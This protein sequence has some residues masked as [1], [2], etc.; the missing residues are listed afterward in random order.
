MIG[1]NALCPCG[2]GDKV[3]RCCGLE[4]AQL[5]I[6]KSSP[7]PAGLARIV[8]NRHFSPLKEKLEKFQIRRVGRHGFAQAADYFSTLF[9]IE[10][11]EVSEY[12][13]VF[14]FY[15]YYTYRRPIS[16]R[17]SHIRDMNPEPTAA[18]AFL[19]IS[20]SGLVPAELE[21]LKAQIDS[22]LSFWEVVGISGNTH[23]ELIDLITR[24]QVTIEDHGLAASCF[25]GGVCLAAVMHFRGE[26][27]F[28]FCARIGL[29]P[30][31]KIPLFEI[32][33]DCL[34]KGFYGDEPIDAESME[35]LVDDLIFA[36]VELADH[37]L[38]PRP[39]QLCNTDGDPLEIGEMTFKTEL[40]VA[41]AVDALKC[42]NPDEQ[43]DG[44]ADKG[45]VRISWMRES[46]N[47]SSG[48]ENVVVATFR[49]SEGTIVAEVNSRKRAKSAKDKLMEIFGSKCKYVKAKYSAP[50]EML[51]N[52]IDLGSGKDAST[53][54][55]G[56]LE[57]LPPNARAQVLDSV[58]N[59]ME[60]KSIEW[61]DTPI[62]MLGNK[63]PRD[64]VRNP[65]DAEKLEALLSSF[66]TARRA[67]E[68]SSGGQIVG[69][70]IELIRSLLL[71]DGKKN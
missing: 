33:E 31:F 26:Y 7:M 71:L 20:G 61:I 19:E 58:R 4:K 48:A 63:T 5:M 24:K 29:P 60:K 3:K 37:V 34:G 65:R 22:V 53:H 35:Y 38:H 69:M 17:D 64:A 45:P 41:E 18:E 50:G 66:E 8:L 44:S 40:S 67:Q 27:H 62:P 42:L 32:L 68:K 14:D 23:V 49:V 11:E 16:N 15:F 43:V 10:M 13:D 57:N 54:M 21:I 2:S 6:D 51:M 12:F 46:K 39:P 30:E 25:V 1:R 28:S 56:G 9:A 52:K 59:L 55:I 36:Y 47:R 70:N